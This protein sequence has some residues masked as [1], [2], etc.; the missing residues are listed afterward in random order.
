M[1]VT[2]F[3]GNTHDFNN[4]LLGR[5]YWA[6]LVNFFIYFVNSTIDSGS[7]KSNPGIPSGGI[8]F[9]LVY[10]KKSPAPSDSFRFSSM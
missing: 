2:L 9:P 1:P 5:L 10:S 4:E 6:K 8:F 3:Q 7:E